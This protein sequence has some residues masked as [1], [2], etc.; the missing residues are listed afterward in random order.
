MKRYKR[1]SQTQRTFIIIS[2]IVALSMLFSLC[3]FIPSGR[4]VVTPTPP[5]LTPT[6]FPTRTPTAGPA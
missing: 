5:Y 1:K 4:R 2:M 3:L 6:P